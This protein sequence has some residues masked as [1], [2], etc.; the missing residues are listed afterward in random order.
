MGASSSSPSSSDP[1]AIAHTG[2]PS[3]A[4]SGVMRLEKRSF[5]GHGVPRPLRRHRGKRRR[6]G[7]ASDANPVLQTLFFS[8]RSLNCA[9]CPFCRILAA[10]MPCSWPSR[11]RCHRG[12][13][14]QE[15][16]SLCAWMQL[17]KL[18]KTATSQGLQVRRASWRDEAQHDVRGKW[19]AWLSGWPRWR[20]C[21]P[22]PREGSHDG[23]HSVWIQ[24]VVDSGRELQDR[25]RCCPSVLGRDVASALGPGLRGHD[26]VGLVRVHDLHQHVQRATVHAEGDPECRGLPRVALQLSLFHTTATPPDLMHQQKAA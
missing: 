25:G 10:A 18:R 26:G 7:R 1:S 3:S 16:R 5:R 21:W 20:G 15:W 6:C 9:N 19:P 24:H 2:G 8:Q 4:G 14:G 22:W 12:R 23:P 11:R 17:L 13:S